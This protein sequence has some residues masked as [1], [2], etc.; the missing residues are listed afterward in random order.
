MAHLE[1]VCGPVGIAE[2]VVIRNGF[3]VWQG[4]R[5]TTRRHAWSCTKSF[6]SVCLGLLWD[7]GKCEPSS[8]AW[9]HFP[10]LRQHYPSVTLEHLATFTSGYG[11]DEEHPLKPLPPV[12]P[13]GTFFHYTAQSDLLAAILTRI[14]GEP[15]ERLFS[16]R[17]GCCIGLGDPDFL[18]PAFGEIDGLLLHGGSGLPGR[19]VQCNAVGMARFGWLHAN[20]GVWDGTRL[21]SRRY[22]DY[23]V[24]PRVT[25]SM[26]TFDS[27]AWYAILPGSYGLNWWTNGTTPQGRRM[28]PHA[29]QGTFAAQ[30]NNNNICIIIPSWN[31]VVVRWG[32]DH[33]IDTDLYDPLFAILAEGSPAAFVDIDSGTVVD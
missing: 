26:P 1:A 5:A 14:A 21:L 33:V 2:T 15:L 32:G 9:P 25:P 24:V 8:L 4:S 18:W 31:M 11:C 20:G 3:V 7:D 23:A 29:P 30:G 16:R 13:P 12:F 27:S 19:G 17:I 28:W 22:L 6:L 10:E